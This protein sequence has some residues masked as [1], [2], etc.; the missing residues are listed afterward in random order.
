MRKVIPFVIALIVSFPA[1]VLFAQDEEVAEEEVAEE[2]VDDRAAPRDARAK[3]DAATQAQLA[4]VLPEFEFDGVGLSDVIDFLRDVTNA[5]IFVNWRA[6]EGAGIDRNVPVNMRLRQ[7]SFGKALEVM[8]EGVGGDEVPLTY[9]FDRG[10]ITISTAGPATHT[11]AYDVGDILQAKVAGQAA[12][13][14]KRLA[15]LT[16]LVTGSVAPDS[17]HLGGGTHDVRAA[18]GKLLIS[19]TPANHDAVANLLK[20]TRALLGLPPVEDPAPVVPDAKK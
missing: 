19:Q 18:D 17:W 15:T 1:L 10:V 16:K 13:A 12:D 6:L 20:Q 5:N 3:P 7:V 2:A 8:L 9:T 4:R 11:R 14:A